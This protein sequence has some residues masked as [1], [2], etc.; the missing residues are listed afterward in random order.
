MDASAQ[1]V[2]T[3]A[4][5]GDTRTQAVPTALEGTPTSFGQAQT[6]NPIQGLPT[7]FGQAQ[8]VAQAPV[9]GAPTS[10]GQAQTAPP[11]NVAQQVTQKYGMWGTGPENSGIVNAQKVQAT[12]DALS[13]IPGAGAVSWVMQKIGDLDRIPTTDIASKAAVLGALG[14]PTMA[15]LSQRL[16]PNGKFIA[17]SHPHDIV[18]FYKDKLNDALPQS[19]IGNYMRGVVNATAPI[20]GMAADISMNLSSY[21]GIGELTPEA[22]ALSKSIE[23]AG[24][25]AAKDKFLVSMGDQ[26]LRMSDVG[27]AAQAAG[28]AVEALPGGK[29]VIGAAQTAADIAKPAVDKVAS[30]LR[31]F[32]PDTKY[33]DVNAASNMYDSKSRAEPIQIINNNRAAIKDL[34]LTDPEKALIQKLGERT[35]N[36]KGNLTPELIEAAGPS[37]ILPDAPKFASEAEIRWDASQKLDATAKEMGVQVDPGRSEKIVDGLMEAKKSGARY[38]D[39]LVGSGYIDEKN[40]ADKVLENHMAHVMDP[41]YRGNKSAEELEEVL[42]SK[43]LPNTSTGVASSRDIIRMRKMLGDVHGLNAEIEAETGM[44]SFFLEDPFVA[45]TEREVR[46]AK[47]ARDAEYL[48]LV[49]TKGQEMTPWQA[50]KQ[51]MVKILHPD[52]EGRQIVVKNAEG[53]TR[54]FRF[55]D[56]YFDKDTAA[57]VSDRIGAQSVT[58]VQASLGH[59]AENIIKS[60]YGKLQSI[61]RNIALSNPMMTVRNAQECLIKAIARGTS[62]DAFKAAWDSVRGKLGEFEEAL[63]RSGVS[64]RQLEAEMNGL[65]YNKTSIMNEGSSGFI[66]SAKDVMQKGAVKATEDVARNIFQYTAKMGEQGETYARK[67]LYIEK[68]M[69]GFDTSMAHREVMKYMFDF[70]YRSPAMEFFRTLMP[71]GQHAWK[72][73]LVAP[74]LLATGRGMATYNAVANQIPRVV[75]N[76]LNDPTTQD[77]IKRLLP[78]HLQVQNIIAGP[79]IRPNTWMGAVFGAKPGKPIVPYITNEGAMGVLQSLDVFTKAGRQA[80]ALGHYGLDSSLAAMYDIAMGKDAYSGKPILPEDRLNYFVRQGIL[81]GLY[82]NTQKV[83][84][85]ASGIGNPQYYEPMTLRLSRL[86]G[87]QMGGLTDI[88]GDFQMGMS[89]VNNAEKQLTQAYASKLAQEKGKMGPNGMS[90]YTAYNRAPLIP[91]SDKEIFADTVMAKQQSMAENQSQAALLSTAMQRVQG[92]LSAYDYASRILNIQQKVKD[93]NLAFQASA[94]RFIQMAQGAKSTAEARQ[95]AGVKLLGQ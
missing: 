76:A 18:E 86:L 58:S 13:A 35:Q 69:Q 60:P 51:N 43:E 39:T 85:Q 3:N 48:N 44:K 59:L 65:G 6:G 53:E 88:E 17:D 81:G 87:T 77:A 52:F 82:P 30:V 37:A 49:G 72:T 22:K 28:S 70:G 27:K 5:P 1:A 14:V 74:E 36:F 25:A 73:A 64:G 32:S 91:A 2:D 24:S 11:A 89:A 34:N 80:N 56:Q 20:M 95:K 12:K 8:T 19:Q 83:I 79:I 23:T 90:L 54:S 16:N 66:D 62:L 4:L 21:V 47:L 94:M 38:I 92:N 7:S 15:E 9:Q 31:A 61:Q 71:F 63:G 67:A 29:A 84:Q 78:A 55:G 33:E 57:K 68:R 50:Q 40:I 26:G 75:A 45:G 93:M 41:A 46:A 42:N 10:F